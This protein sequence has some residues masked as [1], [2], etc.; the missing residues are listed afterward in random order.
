MY[1][2]PS[3]IF[4][5]SVNSLIIELTLEPPGDWGH[6]LR[7]AQHNSRWISSAVGSPR[8]RH[9]WFLEPR[10][11]LC[12]QPHICR[13]SPPSSAV[14]FTVEETSH[15]C[16]PTQFKPILFKGQLGSCWK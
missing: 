3:E 14:V 16:G 8:V 12:L 15:V 1:S 2:L 4:F 6:W 5:V 13:L 9:T 10:A 11:P 7:Y